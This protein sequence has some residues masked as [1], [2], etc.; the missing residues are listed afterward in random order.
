MN[1]DEA[2]DY[3]MNIGFF[4]IKFGLENVS[5]LLKKLGDPHK[6]LK[7]I[8]IA[9]TNGKGSTAAMISAVLKQK[10]K[11]GLYTSPHLVRLNE[12][13]KI[14]DIEIADLALTKLVE[15]VKGV[16]D[17]QTY[18]ETVFAMA[19]FYFKE[20]KCDYVVLEVGMGGRLDATN[21]V[22]PLVTVITNISIE[23]TKFLGKTIKKIAYEKAG[24]IKQGIPVI[25]AACRE[26]QTVFKVVC[27]KRESQLHAVE[28]MGRERYDCS[29]EGEFQEENMACAVKTMELLECMD[30]D[31]IKSGLRKIVWPGRMERRGNIL[32]DCAH[33][34]AAF[35]GLI[36]E[37]RKENYNRLI[38]VFGMLSDKDY[39]TILQKIYPISDEFII[40]K[41]D[42]KR[43]MEPS[44]LA[45]GLEEY[46]I[47]EIPKEAMEYAQELADQDD[48]IVVCGSIYLIGNVKRD[49][50]L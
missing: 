1:Y 36:K 28:R 50:G 46:K 24:I 18:F 4:R 3:L 35:D 34:P 49:C 44:V 26:A 39:R 27:E 25:S 10:Y 2:V 16:R 31:E 47:I 14:N 13:I 9:G 21:V 6:G 30:N 17:D 37:L 15:R 33:N 20:Q 48:L 8:H 42:I 5:K 32:L 22:E 40:T 11:V 43:A 19:M 38:V 7:I 45:E 41:P 23:H 12:R 29:L